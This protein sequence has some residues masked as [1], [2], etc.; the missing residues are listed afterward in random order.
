MKIAILTFDEPEF[1]PSYIN[2]RNFGKGMFGEVFFTGKVKMSKIH[3]G[4]FKNRPFYKGLFFLF[5][6]MYFK[7]KSKFFYSE[8]IFDF[9]NKNNI[10]GTFF[11]VFN[12]IDK[13]IEKEYLFYINIFKKIIENGHEL[14]LH[15]YRHG[16]LTNSECQ[17]S[18]KLARELL[19]TELQTYSSPWG[20]DQKSTR[21]ILCDNGFI[22][23]RVWKFDDEISKNF[24][25]ARYV[26]NIDL[27][28]ELPELV[29]LNVHGP[30][31]YPVGRKK[32]QSYIDILKSQN[33]VFMTF[34][35]FVLLKL[36]EVNNE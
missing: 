19:N 24:I 15:G 22:G 6:Q 30:D 10:K 5:A 25:Q 23:F 12:L 33:Y 27:H 16:V 13:N 2:T 36:Q 35:E 7:L 26:N 21:K 34:K 31:F 4:V 18:I 8:T 3:T 20:A 14:G 32:I 9:L 17:H 29:V 28:D 1:E 11:G